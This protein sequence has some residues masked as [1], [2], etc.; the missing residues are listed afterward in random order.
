MLTLFASNALL[1]AGF[2]PEKATENDI[3]G[4]IAKLEKKAK[5]KDLSAEKAD[6]LEKQINTLKTLLSISALPKADRDKA[7]LME[8]A[9][10]AYRDLKPAKSKTVA[11]KVEI[12]HYESM[13]TIP[14]N[15][16]KHMVVGCFHGFHA[17]D[18]SDH[19]HAGAITVN[20]PYEKDPMAKVAPPRDPNTADIK[21][22]ITDPHFLENAKVK[23]LLGTLDTIYL[24]YLTT[25]PLNKEQTYRNALALLKPGGRLFFDHYF[26]MQLVQGAH[27]EYYKLY[28]FGIDLQNPIRV[29]GATEEARAKR[30]SELKLQAIANIKE[31]LTKEK[32]PVGKI[33]VFREGENPFNK[34]K[35]T[36][37]VMIE[38]VG[39][40]AAEPIKEEQPKTSYTPTKAAREALDQ[41]RQ[42]RSAG[43]VDPHQSVEE[44]LQLVTDAPTYKALQGQGVKWIT[45]Q[46]KK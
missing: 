5:S 26:P 21:D 14:H 35:D 18:H 40:V 2:D 30:T 27:P 1:K 11:Q 23:P 8:S 6:V 16:G 13:D 36:T 29:L 41:I 20:I 32:L 33:E 24:E 43:I 9:N 45:E 19:S 39:T 46:L 25:A 34:R 3:R 31:W 44:A 42:L 17:D 28:P 22:D 10:M 37:V 12:L 7:V 15:L 38:K 4:K